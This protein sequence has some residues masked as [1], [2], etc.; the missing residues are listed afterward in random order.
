M[1]IW[2]ISRILNLSHKHRKLAIRLTNN[3]KEFI[4]TGNVKV[5][6]CDGGRLGIGYIL[7]G[8][9]I[10]METGNVVNMGDVELPVYNR[11]ERVWAISCNDGIQALYS[12]VQYD[13]IRIKIFDSGN[14]QMTMNRVVL[15]LNCTV[16][17]YYQINITNQ[18]EH[19][20]SLVTN[21]HS[22]H[23]ETHSVIS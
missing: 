2:S 14:C 23:V 8:E 6:E 13:P 12:I 18:I 10:I 21:V 3:G 16:V 9:K 20:Y 7:D 11:D 1:H 5:K 17:P 19:Y 22:L 4:C 15:S